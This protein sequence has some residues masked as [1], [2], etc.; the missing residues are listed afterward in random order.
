MVW[1]ISVQYMHLYMYTYLVSSMWQCM[2]PLHDI[3][4]Y[5]K[6]IAI[7]DTTKLCRNIIVLVIATEQLLLAS[8]I[9]FPCC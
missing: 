6:D 3:K 4:P 2:K 7:W 9:L 5:I 1:C 8:G